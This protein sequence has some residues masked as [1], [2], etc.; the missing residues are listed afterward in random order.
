M[1]FTQFVGEEI[2]SS[3]P[4]T[5]EGQPH[6]EGEK[7]L[8]LRQL[9]GRVPCLN[10]LPTFGSLPRA[11]LVATC[12]CALVLGILIGAALSPHSVASL[13]A[14]TSSMIE[15]PSLGTESVVL[16]LQGLNQNKGKPTLFSCVPL[17]RHGSSEGNETRKV[18]VMGGE[19]A[20]GQEEGNSMMGSSMQ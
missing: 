13:E 9:L 3:Q 7:T 19:H 6:N 15:V 14:P 12:A 17:A 10:H 1:R 2:D 5:N 8:Q 18:E 16:S 11:P 4:H 20:V